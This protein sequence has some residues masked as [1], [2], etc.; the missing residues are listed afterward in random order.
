MN[1]QSEALMGHNL[2]KKQVKNS[3]FDLSI[4]TI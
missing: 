2:Q 4:D 1:G 3:G